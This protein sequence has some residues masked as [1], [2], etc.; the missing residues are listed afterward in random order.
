MYIK[1]DY[2]YSL[3]IH[4]VKINYIKKFKKMQE[5]NDKIIFQQDTRSLMYFIPKI[6]NLEWKKIYFIDTSFLYFFQ[7]FIK[8]LKLK[9]E[10]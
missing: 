1:K 10:F 6:Q 5:Y 9:K 4:V 8:I 2:K 3:I 7:L